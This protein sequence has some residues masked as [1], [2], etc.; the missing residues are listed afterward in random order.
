MNKKL[1]SLLLASAVGCTAL[2]AEDYAIITEVGFASEYLFRGV[3]EAGPTIM[4]SVDIRSQGSPAGELYLGGWAA[5]PARARIP[6][7][8]NEV[9][10]Y[11]GFDA[12]LQHNFFVDLGATYFHFPMAGLREDTVEPYL[13]IRLEEIADTWLTAAG[14]IYYDIDKSFTAEA[15]LEYKAPFGGEIPASLDL[16]LFVGFT[17]EDRRFEE[18]YFYYGVSAAVPYRLSEVSTLS[19]GVHYVGRNSLDDTILESDRD[20]LYWTTS[21]TMSF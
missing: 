1:T 15:F 21:V 3:K 14:Y 2:H 13:G 16:G 6:G 18:D 12:E 10:V 17:D 9:N 5:T 7:A 20:F 4:P 11:A 19:A 8:E